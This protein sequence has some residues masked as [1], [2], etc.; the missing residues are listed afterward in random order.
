[1]KSIGFLTIK[2]N[3]ELSYFTKVAA[4]VIS[5]QREVYRFTPLDIDPSTEMVHGHKYNESTAS[6]EKDVFPIPS[7][8]YDRCFYQ[9]N[10]LSKRCQPIVKWLKQRPGTTFLG[11]GLPNKWEVYEA[12]CD[13]HPISSYIPTTFQIYNFQQLKRLLKKEKSIIIKPI[14]GSQGNGIFHI[15]LLANQ[16]TIQTQQ[17][18]QSIEKAFTNLTDFKL[19]SENLFKETSFIGQR[20]FLLQKEHRPFD[21]RILLQ[22]D[23]NGNWFEQGRG[24]RIGKEQGLVSNLHNGG[25]VIPFE[26]LLKAWPPQLSELIQ[27]E[28]LTITEHIPPLLEERFGRL[29]ELG[30]DIGVTEDGAVWLLDINS[31]P[32]RKVLT[33]ITPS[34]HVHLSQAPHL[35]IDF[36]E[37]Q[38]A[39]LK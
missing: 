27:E 13:H 23:K 4:A 7:Y 14:S 5:N 11:L 12:I 28:I 8:I 22:K 32:G 38:S 10:E 31:K 26:E 30:L 3:Q 2:K 1:M 34:S 6:W 15:R 18:G 9:P 24:V 16:V 17:R 19:F 21:I 35:Y 25:E 39:N 33:T 29:F 37:Q 20:Y 36:L